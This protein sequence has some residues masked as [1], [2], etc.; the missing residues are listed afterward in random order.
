MRGEFYQQLTNDLET[1]RAEGL[2]KEERIITSAQQA[3]ITVADGS[4]VINFCANNYLGLANHPDLIAAAKAANCHEFIE[5]LPN[6]YQTHLAE[7][8]KMVLC[9]KLF[10]FESPYRRKI[11]RFKTVLVV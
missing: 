6:G 9:H 4:H 11:R 2:F 7:G 8:G 5:R 10:T 1:A 3:D